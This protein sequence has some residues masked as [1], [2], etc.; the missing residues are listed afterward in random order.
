[1]K[2]FKRKGPDMKKNKGD[3]RKETVLPVRDGL[4][5]DQFDKTF[6]AAPFGIED[7]NPVPYDP[8]LEAK[9]K[10]K[11]LVGALETGGFERAEAYPKGTVRKKIKDAGEAPER[12]YEEECL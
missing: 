7:P 1:M 2:M 4:F 9:E 10:I 3:R 6:R 5:G 8:V 11:N 12:D